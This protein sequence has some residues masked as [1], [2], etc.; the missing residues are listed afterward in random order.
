MAGQR[1][2][3]DLEISAK[4]A[5]A[6]DLAKEGKAANEIVRTLGIS[7]MT[8]HRCLSTNASFSVGRRATCELAFL[9]RASSFRAEDRS[10][11]AANAS[12]RVE[13]RQFDRYCYRGGAARAPVRA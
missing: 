5:L 7:I 11:A 12:F 4:L 10:R 13:V 9:L 1:R 3:T 8:L 6:D 2:H